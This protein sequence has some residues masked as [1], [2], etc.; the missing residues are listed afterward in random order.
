[1]PAEI[2][3]ILFV[4]FTIFC[5][6]EATAYDSRHPTSVN[7]L[8][9]RLPSMSTE[10][11]KARGNFTPTCPPPP[12]TDDW[13]FMGD[14]SLLTQLAFWFGTTGL[15][16]TACITVVYFCCCCCCSTGH[17]KP[18]RHQEHEPL[19]ALREPL[20]PPQ[21]CSGPD[22]REHRS[23]VR[24]LVL[25]TQTRSGRGLSSTSI[26]YATVYPRTLPAG[27]AQDRPPAAG[28]GAGNDVGRGSQ[29]P[30]GFHVTSPALVVPQ[31]AEVQGYGYQDQRLQA[32]FTGLPSYNSVASSAPTM[33]RQPQMAT[34]QHGGPTVV[35]RS[36]PPPYPYGHC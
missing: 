5:P 17:R 34:A 20:L 11:P 32:Y 6:Y 23:S 4:V 9:R 15:L 31:N 18:K 2:M 13:S 1:M 35:P 7:P 22:Q 33:N 29:S 12:K 14:A 10:S 21:P 24:P 27:P 19:S 36:P 28:S 30:G 26:T 8:T 25:S 3:F 16:L